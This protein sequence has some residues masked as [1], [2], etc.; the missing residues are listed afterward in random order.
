MA[1]R[2]QINRQ[3]EVWDLL[4][5]CREEW[6][7]FPVVIKAVG[8]MC[9]LQRAFCKEPSVGAFLPGGW[10]HMAVENNSCCTI[11]CTWLQVSRPNYSP[12]CRLAQTQRS[13]IDPQ[14]ELPSRT[15]ILQRFS[16]INERKLDYISDQY[17]RTTS[18]LCKTY[19]HQSIIIPNP[20]FPII[21]PVS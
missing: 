4:N 2:N 21:D 12:N 20:V 3:T 5:H 19:L 18:N 10:S 16:Y 9:S 8:Y 6:F 13:F 15:I 17:K 11:S 1:L 7:Y 14:G